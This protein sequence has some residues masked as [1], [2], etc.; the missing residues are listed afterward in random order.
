MD[1]HNVRH[2]FEHK[3]LP[4]WFFEDKQKF[5]GLV[6]HDKSVLFRVINSIFEEND[7]KNPYTESDFD[8]D[9]SR[10]TEDIL[11][12]KIIFPEPEEEPLCYCSYMFFDEK[13]EQASYFCI[14]K[15]DEYK[16][17]PFVCGWTEQG[18]HINYG[19]CSSEE[20]NDFAKCIE[21]HLN[22]IGINQ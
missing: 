11:M 13:F 5:I 15:S 1:R 20:Y 4:Q 12:L 3:V 16:N 19:N 2:V 6:F 21:I 10:V 7:V 18:V 8:I 9:A 17:Y 22:R 14:E